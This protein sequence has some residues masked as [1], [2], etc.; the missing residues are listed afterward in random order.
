MTRH[1]IFL[2]FFFCFCVVFFFF[3]ALR[4]L[5]LK[6]GSERK[7]NRT[8]HQLHEYKEYDNITAITS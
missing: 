5:I 1:L 2:W 8:A 7:R 6:K 4:V 3:F